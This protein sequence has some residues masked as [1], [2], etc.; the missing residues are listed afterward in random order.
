LERIKISGIDEESRHP[1]LERLKVEGCAFI[2]EENAGG[3]LPLAGHPPA[4]P[5]PGQLRQGPHAVPT[6]FNS[7]LGPEVLHILTLVSDRGSYLLVQKPY[8]PPPKKIT[9]FPF[10]DAP[11]L[12]VFCCCLFCIY[13]TQFSL[14]LTVSISLFFF[15]F[16]HFFHFPFSYFVHK[17]FW[18]TS[19]LP[20]GG[21]G[22]LIYTPGARSEILP[23]GSEPIWMCCLV[24]NA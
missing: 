1:L 12:T 21:G 8:P 13:F 3:G 6:V 23:T 19:P 10:H 5:L 17:C 2:P 20:G 14:H 16:R 24:S 4:S 11:I 18:P 22:F 9:F 15:K 7:T